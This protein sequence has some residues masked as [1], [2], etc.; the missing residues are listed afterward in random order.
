MAELIISEF[1][2]IQ[3]TFHTPKITSWS[4]SQ[5]LIKYGAN[6]PDYFKLDTDKTRF[7]S[8]VGSSCLKR[9]IT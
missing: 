5:S 8:S 3:I 6:R 4:L 2:Y 1:P 7:W 9:V